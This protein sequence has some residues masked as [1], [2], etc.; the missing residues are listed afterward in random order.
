MADLADYARAGI[1]LAGS[2]FDLLPGRLGFL[3][4][5]QPAPFL[6]SAQK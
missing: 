1:G 2:L 5:L 6:G 3:E 4:Y